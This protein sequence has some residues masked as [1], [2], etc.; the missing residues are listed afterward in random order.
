MEHTVPLKFRWDEVV[1]LM[2]VRGIKT[3]GELADKTKINRSN[4]YKMSR[5]DDDY[6]DKVKPSFASVEKLCRVLDCQPGDL[7]RFEPDDHS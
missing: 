2:D 5:S 1:K 4:L 3:L 7:L 6:S